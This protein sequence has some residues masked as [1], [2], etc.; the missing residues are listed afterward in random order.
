MRASMLCSA[1]T[2]ALGIQLSFAARVTKLRSTAFLAADA[3]AEAQTSTQLSLLQRTQ[4]E[5]YSDIDEVQKSLKLT[6]VELQQWVHKEPVNTTN[7]AIVHPKHRTAYSQKFRG[8]NTNSSKVD[9]KRIANSEEHTPTMMSPKTAPMKQNVAP[10]GSKPESK[11][12]RVLE[13]AHTQ[14]G[15]LESL[16]KHLKSNIVNLNKQEEKS[17]DV[18]AKSIQ[19]L[20]ARLKADKAELQKRGL[21]Q[22]EHDR[23]VNRTRTDTF[24]LQYWTRDRSLGHQMFHTN[25]KMEHG[26]MSRVHQVIAACKDAA[27]KGHMDPELMKKLKA[28]AVP[29]AFVQMKSTLEHRAQQYYAHVLTARWMAAEE[30]EAE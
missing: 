4:K 23:L 28:Q 8:N 10:A 14:Q 16:F 7:R 17:K 11:E 24:E 5:M 15:I 6:L 25:L 22:F 12:A 13:V 21:S 3:S 9:S 30:S 18:A 19:R 20:Q 26:L 29:N 27:V 2:V 1:L